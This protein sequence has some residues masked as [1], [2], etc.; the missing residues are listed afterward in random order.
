MQEIE[1]DMSALLLRVREMEAKGELA[2]R[3]EMNSN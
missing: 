2:P 1:D 3:P